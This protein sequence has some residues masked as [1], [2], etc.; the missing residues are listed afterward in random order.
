MTA[1]SCATFCTKNEKWRHFWRAQSGATFGHLLP[2]L[3]K[4]AQSGLDA[5]AGPRTAARPTHGHCTALARPTARPSC[6]A[7]WE[8]PGCQGPRPGSGGAGSWPGPGGQGPAARARRPGPSGQGLVARARRPG[9]SGQGPAASALQPGPAARGRRPGPGGKSPAARARRPEHGGQGP[10]A[11]GR[12]PGAGGQGL[13]NYNV[14]WLVELYLII[15]I[16]L[17]KII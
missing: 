16:T 17:Y 4:V 1:T 15:Y 10:T 6:G 5:A 14:S 9:P 13:R 8:G 3:H 11:R 2:K 12:R 7:R